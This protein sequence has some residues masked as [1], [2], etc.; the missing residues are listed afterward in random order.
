[1]LKLIQDVS[2]EDNHF[3]KIESNIYQIP[4]T[5]TG[6]EGKYDLSNYDDLTIIIPE[7]IRFFDSLCLTC[8]ATSPSKNIYN[9]KQPKHK[10]IFNHKSFENIIFSSLCFDGISIFEVKSNKNIESIPYYVSSYPRTIIVTDN[11]PL[12]NLLFKD[13]QNKIN[14]LIIQLDNIKTLL[15]CN[16]NNNDNDLTLKE[17]KNKLIKYDK[18]EN[19]LIDINKL[20]I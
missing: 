5:Y 3:I 14:N 16:E 1:M 10:L 11:T 20:L 17:L 15:K 18:I 19:K 9:I 8:S 2:L 7:T 6:I 12:L 13:L 4:A